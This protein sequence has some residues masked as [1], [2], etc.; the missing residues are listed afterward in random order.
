MPDQEI[1][2]PERLGHWFLRLNGCMTI[3]NYVSHLDTGSNQRTE[4]DA[5]GVRFPFRFELPKML[6]DV[7][8]SECKDKPLVVVAEIKTGECSLNAAWRGSNTGTL[9][10]ALRSAGMFAETD[11]IAVAK[12]LQTTGQYDSGQYRANFV[13]IGESR[14]ETLAA[15][16]PKSKQ[17][18][19]KYV[20]AF[21]HNR[22][23]TFIKQKKSHPQWD[24]TGQLLWRV[25]MRHKSVEDFISAVRVV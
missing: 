10:R 2:K 19:W 1:V 6:D 11:S 7:F 21:I 23:Q 15:E 8:F 5:L 17:Y 13:A 14:N 9:S 20:L 16:L 25:A 24:K 4:I 12:A 18:E 3:A 22:F